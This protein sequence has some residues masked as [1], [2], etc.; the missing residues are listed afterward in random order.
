MDLV[1]LKSQ[2]RTAYGI[3]AEELNGALT[4]TSKII[5]VYFISPNFSSVY[6]KDFNKYNAFSTR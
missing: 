3:D 1:H 6:E 2:L 4:S 5:Q